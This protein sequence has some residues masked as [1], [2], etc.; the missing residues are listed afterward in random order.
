MQPAG[1]AEVERAK[2][3]GRWDVAYDSPS[4]AQVPEDLTSALARNPKA[5]ASFAALNA[6]NRYAILHRLMTAKKPETRVRQIEA[7]VAMLVAGKTLHP[8]PTKKPAARPT[9]AKAKPRA[10]ASR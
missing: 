4:T 6:T 8:T 9:R 3:D 2:A 5:K 7:F 1:L 10:T